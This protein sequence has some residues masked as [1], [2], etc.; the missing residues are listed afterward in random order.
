MQEKLSKINETKTQEFS[1]IHGELT[2]L[3]VFVL[4]NGEIGLIDIEVSNIL[5]LNTTGQL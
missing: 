3:H 2:P 4:E 1:L 5:M